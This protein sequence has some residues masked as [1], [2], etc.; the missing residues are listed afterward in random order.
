MTLDGVAIFY[1]VTSHAVFQWV[2]AGVVHP[3]ETESG[4]LRFCSESIP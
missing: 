4:L 2:E 1:D 3:D